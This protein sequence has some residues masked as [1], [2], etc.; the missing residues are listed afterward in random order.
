MCRAAP[1]HACQFTPASCAARTCLQR[2]SSAPHPGAC[3]L[4]SPHVVP[5]SINDSLKDVSREIMHHQVRW[6]P[7]S[8]LPPRPAGVRHRPRLTRS[9]RP[10]SPSACCTPTWFGSRSVLQRRRTCALVGGQGGG[11]G[12]GRE[13]ERMAGLL[14]ARLAHA[15][16]ARRQRRAQLPRRCPLPCPLQPWSWWL[17][18]T[19]WS[20]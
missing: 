13:G 12:S 1:R 20:W 11:R 3:P 7:P 18:E 5:R 4:L 17:A 19:C 10:A 2:P 6:W 9:P 8:A 15:A 16:L 14:A